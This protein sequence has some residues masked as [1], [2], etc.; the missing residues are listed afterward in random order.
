[1]FIPPTTITNDPVP[2]EE[3]GN[4]T[5]LFN[6]MRNIGA[7]I[8]IA[9]V[10][11][12]VARHQQVYT[13]VLGEYVNPFSQQAQTMLQGV[14][15]VL[16]AGGADAVSATQQAYATVFGMVQQQ[17]VIMSFND[18]FWLLMVIYCGGLLLP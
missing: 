16:M 7:S 10:T 5:S 13:N 9:T 15:A 14:R 2:K 8:G 18:A 12:I 3:M 17:A 11:T 4:A 1:M 6:L